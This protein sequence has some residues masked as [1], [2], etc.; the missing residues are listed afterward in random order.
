MS[1]FYLFAD[2]F[3]PF[4]IV[5]FNSMELGSF[6]LTKSAYHSSIYLNEEY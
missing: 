4:F 5:W 6:V 1:L 2:V 3:F